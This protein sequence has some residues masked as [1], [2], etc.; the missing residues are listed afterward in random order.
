MVRIEVHG[1]STNVL[2]LISL[3]QI[4]P[5]KN[6]HNQ[7]FCKYLILENG[8]EMYISSFKAMQG[9]SIFNWVYGWILLLASK[10]GTGTVFNMIQS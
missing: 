4:I 8:W 6:I 5:H 1:T 3:P 9:S 7:F 2:V 10:T